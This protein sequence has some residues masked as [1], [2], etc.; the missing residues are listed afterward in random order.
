[1]PK[2]WSAT[3]RQ[4]GFSVVEVL[5]AATVFGFLATAIIGAIIYGR[6]ST[7]D[8][9]ARAR[10]N[11]VADEGVEAVRNIRDAGYASLTNGTYGLVQ[12]GNTW[13]LSGS[14]DITT[15]QFTRSVT[16]ADNGSNRKLITSNVNWNSAGGPGQVSVVSELTNWMSTLPKYWANATQYVVRDLTGTIAGYKVDTSGS[17]A[18]LVR[19]SATG[20]NFFVINISTP[21][22]PTVVGSLTLAGTPTNVAVSGNYAYVSNSS[23]TAELQ[24][25]NV[26]TPTAPAL[27]GTYNATGTAGGR[28]VYVV[29][30]TAYLVRGANAASDEFVIVNAST[31][32]SP[33]RIGGY[34]L[35][36]NMNEVYVS[37]TTAYVAT[38][39]DT[40]EVLVI[41]MT[42]PSSLTLGTAINLS[43]TNDATTIAGFGTTIVVGQGTI[44]NT[45][46]NAT[47]LAPTFR[48]SLTMSGAV[49]DVAVDSTHNY[50]FA[51]L[52]FA[53][54]EFA[55]INLATITAPAIL[56]TVDMTG[57]FILNGVCYNGTYDIVVGASSNTAGEAA[58]FGP[59]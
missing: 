18:Y 26:T 31:P 54:G 14:S 10:A 57:S 8:G 15:S 41:N 7:A 29:G 22:N 39:S 9:G 55:A 49:Q 48:G 17:Y 51:G 56:D 11:M 38:A 2:E 40:Q 45:V 43:G 5:L 20:P 4:R 46:T 19:N 3:K 33:T 6:A 37:G 44:F 58:I 32:T 12:S 23:S 50:A 24:I 30:T 47:A 21:T 53:T 25:V 28:G 1:M 16:I 27:A 36:V 42:T 59:N 35:S 13:T 34:P 52:N